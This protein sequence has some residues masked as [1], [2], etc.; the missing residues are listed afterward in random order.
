[1]LS[2][3]VLSVTYRCPIRCR[4]CGVNAGPHR[5]EQMSL[6]LIK[7]LIDEI[8]SIGLTSLVVFTGGEPFLLGDDLYSGV[9][10]AA[11]RGFSTRIVTNAYWAKSPKKAKQ[12]LTRL[13]EIGLTE[14]NFS[15]DDFHQEFIPLERIKW[16][17]EEALRVGLPALIA[18]RGIKNS[19]ITVEYLENY[20]GVK[21]T[22]FQK[23]KENPK[24]NVVNY[25]ITVPVGWDSDK[26]E[27]KDYLYPAEE[28]SWKRPCS[29]ALERVV[30]TPVGDLAI[31]CGIGSEEFPETTFGNIHE[32]PLVDLLVEANDDLIV[33]W[34]A[35]EG[36]FG[37]MRFIQRIN[38]S[39]YFRDRYVNICHLCHDIFSREE[40]RSV[41]SS[42]VSAKAPSLSFSRAWFE[43]HRSEI[44]SS[45]QN[46]TKSC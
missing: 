2:S 13:I 1:M 20:F 34:L 8:K 39:I 7:K 24:N 37:I 22:Q 28:N 36:P 17:N 23:G 19:K 29:S 42:N 26:L 10:Y 27:D 15:C 45:T 12:I 16:A 44:C 21:L 11:S 18:S 32:K 38:P 9:E 4:Y 46:Q 35:L 43:E 33:N 14:I 40:I 6:A 25:G 30:I 5:T 3:L 31:C 41:L